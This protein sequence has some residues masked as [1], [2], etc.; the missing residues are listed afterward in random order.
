MK[1]GQKTERKK[2]EKK[3]EE[4]K[5]DMEQELQKSP[6]NQTKK[7]KH[8]LSKPGAKIQICHSLKYRLLA[9]YSYYDY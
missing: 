6:K 5:K 7:L 9:L 2:E 4:R 8:I 1:K 3:K